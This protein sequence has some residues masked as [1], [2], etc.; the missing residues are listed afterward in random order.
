MAQYRWISRFVFAVVAVFAAILPARAQQVLLNADAQL[1]SAAPTTNY[2]AAMSLAVNSTNSVVLRYDLTDILPTGVTSS[3]VVKARLIIFPDSVTTKGPFNVYALTSA[4]AEGTVTYATRP[5][6]STTV[7][8]SATISGAYDPIQIQLTSTVQG[9]IANPSTNHGLEIVASG[10]TSFAIDSKE[11]TGTSHPAILQ[12]DLSGPAGATGPTGPQG[13][14][15]PKGATG[16]TGPAGPQGPAGTLTLPF[17]GSASTGLSAFEVFNF[18]T[19]TGLDAFGGQAVAGGTGGSGATFKGGFSSEVTGSGSA[20]GLGI[21]VAGGDGFNDGGSESEPG[22]AGA[23]LIGGDNGGYGAVAY[24]ASGPGEGGVG[25]ES[26]PGHAG[27]Y[28]AELFGNVYVGGTL[29]KPG[30]SF[31]I[32]HPLDPEN[33]YLS[34][35]FVESPDMM[36]IYNGNVVT[37]GSG[38]ATVTM[39][40]WFEALN[41]DFRY[42]LTVIGPQFAQAIVSSEMVANHFTIRTDHPGVKVSWMVTGIRQDAWA[43]ANRIPVEQEKTATEKGHYLHPELFGHKEELAIGALERPAHTKAGPQ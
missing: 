39:P 43:N 22:G 16:A 31:K 36:N 33:K 25:V 42:Q 11:N 32:D 8:G 28:A 5:T 34:H 26:Y 27:G 12:I 30:G 18:G 1:N 9:W 37:D 6:V 35:S 13:P 21:E 29:S 3:Q 10:S 41:T 24:G 7:A 14:A 4:F 23:Y 2:G 20:G 19:G 15:G 40:D 38:Y 17:S